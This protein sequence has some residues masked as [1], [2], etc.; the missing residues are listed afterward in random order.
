MPLAEPTKLP[1]AILQLREQLDQWRGLQKGRKQLPEAFWQAAVELAKQYGVYRTARPLRLDYT[2]L[3]KLVNEPA[4]PGYKPS[5]TTFVELRR[6]S[7]D[8]QECVIEFVSVG[9]ATLRIQWKS[10]IAPDWTGL[11]RAWREAEE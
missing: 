10:M 11:L 9:R 5:Q 3:K 8:A 7:A 1:D 6:R 4:D 2:R